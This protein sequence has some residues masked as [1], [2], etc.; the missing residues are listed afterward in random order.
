MLVTDSGLV[1]ER[2]VIWESLAD[3]D[4]GSSEFFNGS[5]SKPNI[6]ENSNNNTITEDTNT[7][8]E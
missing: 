8:L 5:F 6:Q 4:Q 1:F 7:D 2:S 3:V